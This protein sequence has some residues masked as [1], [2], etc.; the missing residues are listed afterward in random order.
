[1]SRPILYLSGPYSANEYSSVA[2][3]IERARQFALLAWRAGWAAFCPHLNTAHFEDCCTL[4]HADWMDG[5]LT[6]IERMDPDRDAMLMLPYWS[7]SQGAL[8]ER[9]A[10]LRRGIRVYQHLVL[11]PEQ[12]D[13][14]CKYFRRTR[15]ERH[16]YD[17]CASP[18]TVCPPGVSCPIRRRAT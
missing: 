5:D 2:E 9:E 3:N 17:T 1:M 10:A 6:F 18:A 13:E 7:Q 4:A 11:P 14:D 15:Y 16:S 8:Q 12:A